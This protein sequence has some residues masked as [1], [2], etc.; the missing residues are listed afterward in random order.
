MKIV[1]LTYLIHI[2]E[3]DIERFL[4]ESEALLKEVSHSAPR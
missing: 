1:T 3:I 4:S 2:E